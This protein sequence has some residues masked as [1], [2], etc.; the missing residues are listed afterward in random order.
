MIDAPPRRSIRSNLLAATG[1]NVLRGTLGFGAGILMSRLLGP[2]GRGEFAFVASAVGVLVMLSALGIPA[3]VVHGKAKLGYTIEELYG[4]TTVVALITGAAASC[5]FVLLYLLAPRGL[6]AGIPFTEII[7]VPILVPPLLM[8]S[9]WGAVAYA[10]DRIAE[11]GL[12]TTLGSLAFL[13]AIAVAWKLNLLTPSRLIAIWGVTSLLPLAA[14]LR[15]RRLSAVFQVR[16]VATALVRYGLKFNLTALA[17]LLMWRFDVFLV[18]GFRGIREVG[19]YAVAVGVAE[20]LF[21]LAVSIRIA[22][23][24][25]QSSAVD[26]D[27]LVV[28]LGRV[29]RVTL[30]LGAIAC[31]LVMVLGSTIVTQLYGAQFAPSG[32]AVAWLM[33]GILALVMQGP[34]I[35]YLLVEGHILAATVATTGGFLLNVAINLVLLPNHTFVAAAGAST[36]AY[37]ATYIVCIVLF[38]RVTRQPLRSMFRFQRADFQAMRSLLRRP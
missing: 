13:A 14:V 38:A 1:T 7:W 31:V 8:L 22:L 34:F 36:A 3:A 28:I 37:L 30:A 33:P 10:A 25:L 27:Q 29:G 21:Q 16:G 5:L 24:P 19:L 12:A 2:I 17:T 9:H 32:V 15:R 35:D 11:F 6:F 18:K 20:I 26:R 4:A 23:T